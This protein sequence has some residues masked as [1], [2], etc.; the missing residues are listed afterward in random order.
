MLAMMYLRRSES[1]KNTLQI[2]LH[3][4]FHANY[5]HALKINTVTL[6]NF[7]WMHQ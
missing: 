6:T 1:R 2:L 7:T 4:L 5:V 3:P